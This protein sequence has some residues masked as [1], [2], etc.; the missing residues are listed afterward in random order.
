MKIGIFLGY[1]PHVV[2]G[3]EGLGRYIGTL[4]KGF[5]DAGHNVIIAAPHWQLQ[6]LN[7]LFDDFTVDSNSIK[8]IVPANE[9]TL[10][11]I[12]KSLFFRKK[13]GKISKLLSWLFVEVKKILKWTLYKSAE[14]DS[15][16]RL[17]IYALP[18]LFVIVITAFCIT[19]VG[20]YVPL[21]LLVI[22]TAMCIYVAR[23]LL[24]T[25]KPTNKR[26]GL[27]LKITRRIKQKY[28]DVILAPWC[29]LIIKLFR[30]ME[31]FE[32]KRL[33]KIINKS[34]DEVNVW[35]VPSLF[36][37]EV[38]KIE[39]GTVVINAPDL[40][41]EEFPLAFASNGIGQTIP[42]MQ[43]RK[44]LQ[45]GKYFITYCDYV[46]EELLLKE[47]NK[48]PNKVV[49]I[50]HANNDMMPYLNISPAINTLNNTNKNFTKAYARS[51][52]GKYANTRYIFYSSQSRPNKNIVNLIKAFEYLLRKRFINIKL[53][54]TC[55][56]DTYTP[57]G[58]YI[59]E[60]NLET[61]IVSFYNV[62]AKEL[63]ALYYCADLVVNPTI[64]EG[65]FPFTFGEG[66]S[67]GTPSIMSDIPQI[68][69][70]LEPAGLEDIMF[71][72][73]NWKE[74]A[75]KIEYALSH[76]EEMYQ[77]ELPV[78]REMSRRTPA[79]EAEEYVKAFQY[80]MN[81]K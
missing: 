20:K 68:R 10:W 60:N 19:L 79:V 22:F 12:Y 25:V 24:K 37:T 81:Q 34:R 51:F 33:R 71:D 38:L 23:T 70:V 42:V 44:V 53:F 30:N 7:K 39:K 66:M 63:A 15:I 32:Q 47:Y 16:I 9:P 52:L 26:F 49:S 73:Y 55:S 46:R 78:Y 18:V 31:Q 76:I 3:K 62:P 72:P 61:E 1:G 59:R 64:Y 8:W 65:G 17:F 57:V 36:W 13:H 41:P 5:Q 28:V 69:E 56:F 11:R 74:I 54:L 58:E 2:L 75:E 21:I 14:T 80:F 77:L 35:F 40:I 29:D 50:G 43:I 6:S 67:V 4:I 48:T 45:N 27:M